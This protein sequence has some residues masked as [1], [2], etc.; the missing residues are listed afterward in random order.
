MRLPAA[1]LAE[2]Q[3][4][5]KSSHENKRLAKKQ[6]ILGASN[7]FQIVLWAHLSLDLLVVVRQLEPLKRLLVTCPTIAAVSGTG[8]TGKINLEPFQLEGLG[9]VSSPASQQREHSPTDHSSALLAE[10]GRWFIAL[11]F[12]ANGLFVLTQGGN[13]TVLWRDGE[14]RWG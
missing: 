7:S 13:N 8:T 2:G 5:E 14:D 3:D 9:P 12:T 11:C 6:K 4:H 10:Q 1:S